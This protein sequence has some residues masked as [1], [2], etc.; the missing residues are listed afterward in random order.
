[1]HRGHVTL[2]WA[3]KG[4]IVVLF[5]TLLWSGTVWALEVPALQGRVADNANIL[6]TATR[7]LI[8]QQLKQLEQQ[9]ST[10]IVVLTI[11]TLQGESLE[12]YSLKV[13][14]TWGIGQS[15]QD[16]G[17]LLLVAVRDRKLRIE[18][19]YGLEG[20]LTDLIAGRIIRNIITPEFR[21]G[22]YD[23]GVLKG[24]DAMIKTVKGEYSAEM[25]KK[26]E[27]SDPGI[28]IAALFGL[29]FIGTALRKRV[30]FGGIV[31]SLFGGM[32][33]LVSGMLTGIPMLLLALILG[34]LG[35]GLSAL[36]FG[37]TGVRSSGGGS[38]GIY[39]GG[40]GHDGGFRGGGGFGGGGFSGGG[41][42][43]GGGG[44]S[45]GW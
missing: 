28:F 26:K 34:G 17:A 44:A 22:Q 36:F 5:C 10:Q 40:F 4:A 8:N 27:K 2:G 24:V 9:D 41:G 7:S 1:M 30:V 38:G 39:P 29:F 23:Q 25:L 45:G 19:G 35:G 37:I 16:N 3:Q 11:P 15:A 14:E 43:F 33:W 31:G 42:G 18:V 32:L 20:V 6:S 12:E 21:K 13:A